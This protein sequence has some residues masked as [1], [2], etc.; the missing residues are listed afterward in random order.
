MVPKWRSVFTLPK[1]V[2][3]G[4]RQ[5]LHVRP[6]Q[7]KVI[8][9]QSARANNMMLVGINLELHSNNTENNSKMKNDAVQMKL[10]RFA[11]V[12]NYLQMKQ[13]SQNIYAN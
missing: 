7:K 3:A 2:S 8:V 6:F 12:H 4:G 5:K 11:K 10:H 1:I 13:G 9:W